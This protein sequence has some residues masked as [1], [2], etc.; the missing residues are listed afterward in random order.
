MFLRIKHIEWC[1]TSMMSFVGKHRS[2]HYPGSRDKNPVGCSIDCWI[3][4]ENELCDKQKFVILARFVRHDNL[5]QKNTS[6]MNFE[7]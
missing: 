2:L 4:V 3:I 1:K 6:I 5:L 7:A